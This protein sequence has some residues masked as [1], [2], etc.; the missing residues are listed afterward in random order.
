MA[1]KV[2]WLRSVL[3]LSAT[4]RN[5]ALADD[6]GQFYIHRH[7]LIEVFY[8]VHRRGALAVFLV[9]HPERHNLAQPDNPDLSDLDFSDPA[10][11]DENA[12]TE[13]AAATLE[14][15]ANVNVQVIETMDAELWQDAARG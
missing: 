14:Q 15:L 10:I 12:G 11:Y 1:S 4:R 9:A 7:N 2:F 3:T 6:E 8:I 13:L 5:S